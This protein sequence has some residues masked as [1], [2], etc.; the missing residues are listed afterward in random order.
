MLRTVEQ[1]KTEEVTGLSIPLKFDQTE[2]TVDGLYPDQKAVV[3]VVLHTL[4][5]WLEADETST[6]QPL[7]MT[8]NGGGGSGKSVVIHTIVTLMRKMFDCNDV[9]KVVAPTGAAAFNVGGSTIHSLVGANG[10]K[11]EYIPNTMRGATR[12]RLVKQF[13]VLLALIIDE[14]SLATS[15]LLGTA[16]RRI[17][18][19]IYEGRQSEESDWGGLPIVLLSGDDYQLPCIGKGALQVLSNKYGGTMERLGRQVL[20]DSTEF[21]MELE[22]SKRINNDKQ[23]DKKIMEA[24]RLATEQDIPQKYVEKLTGLHIENMIHKHGKAKVEDMIKG[25]TYIFYRNEDRKRH[26]ITQIAKESSPMNP[27]A[28]MPVVSR[29]GAHGKGT[30]CHFVGDIPETAMLCIGSLCSIQQQNFMPSWGLHNHACGTVEEM[31]YAK[32]SN[33]NNGDLPLYVV[34]QFPQYS[35]PAW[36]KQNPKVQVRFDAV[37]VI[38]TLTYFLFLVYSSSRHNPSLQA[39]MLYKVFCSPDTRLCKND[40]LFSGTVC[41]ARRPGQ[42]KKLVQ[43]CCV[44]STHIRIR[45]KLSWFVVYGYI[46]RNNTR[47]R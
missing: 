18:E 14:R 47:R 19:T 31:V 15:K 39:S 23:E 12:M 16:Q 41:R 3:A 43:R 44:R 1:S 5:K 37:L 42:A 2:Y 7:R 9:V 17:A 32:G 8:I 28:R 38:A 40:S 11:A 24:L 30:A 29:G 45:N 13:K 46:T 21:V 10:D 6:F 22:G 36:D 27:V 34:V 33:P 25:F 4:K 20:L 35:G 26:N